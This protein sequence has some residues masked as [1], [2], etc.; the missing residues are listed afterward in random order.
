MPTPYYQAIFSSVV[1]L[2]FGLGTYWSW[3]TEMSYIQQYGHVCFS[4]GTCLNA[5]TEIVVLWYVMSYKFMVSFCL[6]NCWIFNRVSWNCI[7]AVWFS[8]VSLWLLSEDRIFILEFSEK[9]LTDESYKW[10][11]VTEDNV[12]SILSWLHPCWLTDGAWVSVKCLD[13]CLCLPY[14]FLC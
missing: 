7:L 1:V 8:L 13:D 12:F 10:G 9:H 5:S 11:V 3:N 14:Y 4:L 6:Q 2:C